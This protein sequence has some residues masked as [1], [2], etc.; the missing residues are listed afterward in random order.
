MEIVNWGIF[1]LTVGVM[2]CAGIAQLHARNFNLLL[3][4]LFG[5]VGVMLVIV[6]AIHEYLH[7]KSR[8][9]L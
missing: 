4:L 9:K 1:V 3:S 8:R 5:T 7:G 2:I 6:K